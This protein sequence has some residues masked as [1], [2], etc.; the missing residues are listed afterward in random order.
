M[1][2]ERNRAKAHR[3]KCKVTAWAE[4]FVWGGKTREELLIWFLRKHYQSLFR[5]LWR[6]S[7]EQPHFTYQRLGWF[8]FGFDRDGMHP[9]FF[10]RAFYSAEIVQPDDIVLDIGCG[11]GFL[12]NHFLSTQCSQV[13]AIDIEPTAIREATRTNARPNITYW[14]RDAVKESFPREKYDVIVWDGAIGHFGPA[15]TA[16]MLQ[17]ITAALQ[18]N[19]IFV[20]SESLGHE[21][22]DHLQFFEKIEDL[23]SL[24]RRYFSNVL[25]K[26]LRY[27]I[28]NATFVRHEAYWRCSNSST[29]LTEFSWK[30]FTLSDGSAV[31]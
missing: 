30:H 7:K 21:G 17:K 16:R 6:L 25:T 11:D 19:G 27:P 2:G 15:D 8:L 12:T 23:E 14:L 13:H 31:V 29:R 18:D 9:Y 5:R 4:R 3:L 1:L 20:G 28:N 26:T 24:L 10:A 22:H